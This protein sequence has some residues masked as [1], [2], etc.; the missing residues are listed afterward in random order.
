[1]V[2]STTR[3][4]YLYQL[5]FVFHCFVSICH[6]VTTALLMCYETENITKRDSILCSYTGS[7][8]QRAEKRVF[9]LTEL[10]HIF[11]KSFP[12]GQFNRGLIPTESVFFFAE[13]TVLL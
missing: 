7:R 6:S 3:F 12:C 11:A 10:S 5:F 8:L 13:Y 4:L 9:M 1:M 2:C